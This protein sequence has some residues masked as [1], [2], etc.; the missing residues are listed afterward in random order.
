MTDKLK[1]QENEALNKCYSIK[2]A[3]G[4]SERLCAK[5]FRKA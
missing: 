4:Y 1:Q 3:A 2:N 5:C